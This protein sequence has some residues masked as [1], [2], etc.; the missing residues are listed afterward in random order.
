MPPRGT[1]REH[2][3]GT[4]RAQ[5]AASHR[6]A[7]VLCGAD[8]VLGELLRSSSPD[9]S[10]DR[11]VLWRARSKTRDH[12]LDVVG[13]A[14]LGQL[15][16]ADEPVDR[17][18]DPDDGTKLGLDVLRRG[19]IDLPGRG[20]TG[21]VL[22]GQPADNPVHS[23]TVVMHDEAPVGVDRDVVP[24]RYHLAI[25]KH[26]R[27]EGRRDIGIRSPEDHECVTARVIPLPLRIGAGEVTDETALTT[28]LLDEQGD[29]GRLESVAPDRDEV[30]DTGL[31]DRLVEH[32]EPLLDKCLRYVHL[33]SVP[34]ACRFAESRR[35]PRRVIRFSKP[36]VPRLPS[37]ALRPSDSTET[38]QTA[39][40]VQSRLDTEPAREAPSAC[41]DSGVA[42]KHNDSQT[43]GAAQPPGTDGT[44]V[45]PANLRYLEAA[46]YLRAEG[47][48]IR[49]ARLADWLGISPPSVGEGV[50]RLTRDGLLREGEGQ[51]LELTEAGIAAA[52]DLVRRH[53]IVE[54]WAVFTLGLDWV[55][56]DDEA[57][58]LAP[59]VSDVVLDRL[60]AAAGR[61]ACCPHGNVIPG[62]DHP[63]RETERLSE[64]ATGVPAIVDRISEL[65]EHD[66]HEV[67]DVA[68]QATLFPGAVV[69]ITSR[70]PDGA[71]EVDV[72]GHTARI[73]PRVAAAVW[74][75]TGSL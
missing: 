29:Q 39:S 58:R 44:H 62:E 54:A 18:L 38:G 13:I 28:V 48:P 72:A 20:E 42:K 34:E 6:L 25:S 66:A 49:R 35:A 26:P 61:P 19:G 57:Q 24:G 17:D 10:S 70:R 21:L 71:L 30:P 11:L 14:I 59:V 69:S 4:S 37:S 16:G 65:A 47:L 1:D 33:P 2:L 43:S 52:T 31:S 40:E 15:P 9:S 27:V 45:T 8:F 46:Y 74:V 41:D 7:P 22:S 75:T 12:T 68:Y 36:R 63:V 73:W 51:L 55:T 32:L 60:H 64:L 5:L 67:L 23:R 3:A 56:A 53:R 50:A